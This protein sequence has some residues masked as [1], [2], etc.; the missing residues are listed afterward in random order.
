MLGGDPSQRAT[1]VARQSP[2]PNGLSAECHFV[3]L[4]KAEQVGEFLGA[5]N[6]F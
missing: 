6:R 3:R 2:N 5:T 4:V 1:P